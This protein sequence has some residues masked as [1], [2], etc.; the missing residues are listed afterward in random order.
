MAVSKEDRA[1][2]R[3]T[4]SERETWES[5]TKLRKDK[6]IYS[7]ALELGNL[8]NYRYYKLMVVIGKITK[9]M[10]EEM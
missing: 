9:M 5:W 7:Q 6:D 8:S 10:E 3:L 1:I 2:K 4:K